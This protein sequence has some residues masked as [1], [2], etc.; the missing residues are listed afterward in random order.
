MCAPIRH[1]FGHL[2]V[3]GDSVRKCPFAFHCSPLLKEYVWDLSFGF[4]ECPVGS[5]ITTNAKNPTVNNTVLPRPHFTCVFKCSILFHFTLTV[6]K[7]TSFDHT[8]WKQ[9]TFTQ[10]ILDGMLVGISHWIVVPYKRSF[11][12]A[13]ST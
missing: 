8:C 3:L 11:G 9:E 13:A 10:Q 7:V 4:F 1:R 12:C 5:P 2:R 6:K